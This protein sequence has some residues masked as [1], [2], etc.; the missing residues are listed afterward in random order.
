MTCGVGE[1]DLPSPSAQ[2]CSVTKLNDRM[3]E[4]LPD[5][6]PRYYQTYQVVTVSGLTDQHTV[7]NADALP[8]IG[9]P[10]ISIGAAGGVVFVN[11]SVCV[12]KTAVPKSR[13]ESH[14]VW[15]VT[16]V[17]ERHFTDFDKEITFTFVEYEEVKETDDE[18]TPY[19]N[20]AKDPFDP[21]VID[22]ERYIEINYAYY[23]AEADFDLDNLRD[24][25]NSTN[26]S[27][28]II[29]GSQFNAYELLLLVN[30]APRYRQGD[31]FYYRVEITLQQAKPGTNWRDQYIRDQGYRT[32]EDNI[33]REIF[34]DYTGLQASRPHLLDGA[35]DKLHPDDPPEYL[36]FKRKK[37]RDWTSVGI[38]IP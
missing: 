6:S 11:S 7:V 18:D 33:R 27:P 31:E 29:R 17:Y 10:Y 26:E 14:I 21:P 19:H 22:T 28:I 9:D 4:V 24:L 1:L 20:S 12:Q 34:D 13:D 25:N 30:G 37:I 5:G 2:I 16:C 23:V 8:L 15:I 38:D 3:G 36:Q 35:G 32:L